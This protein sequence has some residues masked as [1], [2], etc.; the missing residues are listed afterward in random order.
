MSDLREEERNEQMYADLGDMGGIWY[1]GEE[2]LEEAL[3]RSASLFGRWRR[4]LAPLLGYESG[5]GIRFH[6]VKED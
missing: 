6:K 4:I 1:P 3:E 5:D 2:T